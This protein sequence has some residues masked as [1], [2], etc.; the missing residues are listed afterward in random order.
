MVTK[1]IVQI[2]RHY[3]PHG[4]AC[5]TSW[6]STGNITAALA[7][8]LHARHVKALS[9]E[10][11]PQ[12]CERWNGYGDLQLADALTYD[13]EEFD[14]AVSM[15][16]MVFLSPLEQQELL[17]KLKKAIRPGGALVVVERMLPPGDPYLD[18]VTSRLTLAAKLAAGVPAHEIVN[19]ELSLAG[20]QRPVN[21]A[22]MTEERATEW[23]RYG[24]FAGYIIQ[25][26]TGRQ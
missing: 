1:G 19:K 4:G 6:A 2:G 23:F 16:C 25:R 12:M 18:I 14:F 8:V 24:D 22:L 9:I 3:L 20:V 5:M 21:P 15:L 7:D 17:A 13:F 26:G 10:E 11:S